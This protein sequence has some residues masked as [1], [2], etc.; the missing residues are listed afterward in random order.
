MKICIVSVYNSENCGS[1]L[2]AYA[3]GKKIEQLGH[4]VCYLERKIKGIGTLTIPVMKVLAKSIITGNFGNASLKL[5]FHRNCKKD[6]KNFRTIS[7]K[8]AMESVDCF[9][10]GS[11]TVW[12]LDN[13]YFFENKEKYWGTIFKGKKVISYAP[14]MNDTKITTIRKSDFVIDALKNISAISVRDE[15]SK[16]LISS[17][18]N[19]DITIVCDPTLLHEIDFYK[20]IQKKCDYK[21]FILIYAFRDFCSKAQQESIIR[22]AKKHN[23]K[24]IS[25]GVNRSWCDISVPFDNLSLTSYFENADYVLTNTFHGTIF[26]ILYKKQFVDFGKNSRKVCEL[27]NQF[28]LVDRNV[29]K[30]ENIDELLE[31]N[32]MF[33][34]VD[35]ILKLIRESSIKYLRHSL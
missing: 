32:I 29:N 26:S 17:E 27:L 24:I 28:K 8:E 2:Q 34:E 16:K 7:F 4:E 1:F 5:K 33:E 11:D 22:Y 6:V 12:Y 19:K 10:L 15:Y 3:L 18:T 25:F 14:S 20:S 9:I 31:T 21:D 35:K 30:E 23:K 13:K